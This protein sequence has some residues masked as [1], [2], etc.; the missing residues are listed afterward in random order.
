[1]AEVH[2]LHLT[3]SASLSWRGLVFLSLIWALIEKRDWGW[4][5]PLWCWLL[6]LGIWLAWAAAG[7]ALA[8]FPK[9]G[10][11]Y[12]ARL[13]ELG[14][15]AVCLARLGQD[16]RLAK[17]A[18]KGLGIGLLVAA[19]FCIYQFIAGDFF[20]GIAKTTMPGAGYLIRE[21]MGFFRTG[22]TFTDPNNMAAVF[23]LALLVMLWQKSG[24]LGFGRQS[25]LVGL[26]YLGLLFTLGRS[27]WFGL[28][29]GVWPVFKGRSLRLKAVA[30]ILV[31]I[32]IFWTSLARWDMPRPE[33]ISPYTS[34]TSRLVYWRE[35]LRMSLEN[36]LFGVG[37][38]NYHY[39]FV[40]NLGAR[41][42]KDLKVLKAEPHGLFWGLAAE[43]G[44]VGLGLFVVLAG[45]PLWR[46]LRK[47]D[48][49]NRL[50][51]SLGL[52]VLVHG[53]AHNYLYQE[54]LWTVIG[55]CAGAAWVND[56]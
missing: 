55:F 32:G 24:Q 39:H 56:A 6:V 18:F 50:S 53:A 33:K 1:M 25:F 4:L 16:P 38:K 49:W 19:V 35:A 26:Y 20:F 30:V 42:L 29:V 21:P 46:N 22:G 54:L 23:S 51:L 7:L 27:V 48:D 12:Y 52:F 17:V 3:A 5:K 13:I 45:W 2:L 41:P 40:A 34:T 8:A 44:L 47:L 14:L 15:L 9:A 37:L 43:T 28:L 31:L 10:Y 11:F 36:P